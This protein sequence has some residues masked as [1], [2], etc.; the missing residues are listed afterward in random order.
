MPPTTFFFSFFPKSGSP[1]SIRGTL[2]FVGI[3]RPLLQ[4]VFKGAR[5]RWAG[6]EDFA[7]IFSYDF[8][9]EY[10]K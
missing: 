9:F 4:V 3:P 6:Y 2:F 5:E 7:Y 1:K 8:L 10:V